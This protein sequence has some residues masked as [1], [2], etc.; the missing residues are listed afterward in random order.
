[1]SCQVLPAPGLQHR[2]NHQCLNPAS[3]VGLVPHQ[4]ERIPDTRQDWRAEEVSELAVVGDGR[5]AVR[6]ARTPFTL[7]LG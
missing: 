7:I 5:A 1:M 3:D 2:R 6:R 4:I